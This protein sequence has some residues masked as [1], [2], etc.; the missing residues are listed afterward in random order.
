[1]YGGTTQDEDGRR[2]PL[3][4]FTATA[5]IFLAE[6]LGIETERARRVLQWL[7]TADAGPGPHRVAGAQVRWLVVEHTGERRYGLSVAPAP[8]MV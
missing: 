7:L 3:D 4:E 1:L 6:A 5:V 2:V 8:E